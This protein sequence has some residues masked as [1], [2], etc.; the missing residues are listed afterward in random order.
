MLRLISTILLISLIGNL[1]ICW[2]D[3]PVRDPIKILKDEK[4][5]YDG[6]LFTLGKAQEIQLKLLDGENYKKLSDSYFTEIQD[7]KSIS[8]MQKEQVN[9][10]SKQNSNLDTA[11][12]AAKKDSRFIEIICFA[13]GVVVTVGMVK[14]MGGFGK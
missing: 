13:L 8:S 12:V 10:L 7:L 5:P 3:T 2:A 11:L 9:F 1:N 4:S 6:L 14:V